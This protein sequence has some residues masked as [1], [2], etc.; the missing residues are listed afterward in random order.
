MG[1]KRRNRKPKHTNQ[2]KRT[3]TKNLHT[4]DRKILNDQKKIMLTKCLLA[5][6]TRTEVRKQDQAKI[7]F[8]EKD[9]Y[10]EI[11]DRN[12]RKKYNTIKITKKY[13]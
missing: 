5:W 9:M 8:G 6:K 13:G 12:N 3:N 2:Q 7:I 4:A 1:N 11:L 10:G